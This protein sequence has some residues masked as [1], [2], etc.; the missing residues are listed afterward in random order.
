MDEVNAE[1][2]RARL[3][4]QVVVLSATG[5]ITPVAICS[6]QE[7]AA[8]V[9]TAILDIWG[10][11]EFEDEGLQLVNDARVDHL[12]SLLRRAGVDVDIEGNRT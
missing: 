1:V 3:A 7:L 8:S 11:G 10:Q 6:D 12:A 2:K 5:M 4:V 9:G